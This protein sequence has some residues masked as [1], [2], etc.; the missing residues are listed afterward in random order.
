M[1]N[2]RLNNAQEL[3]K[4]L[5][6]LEKFYIPTTAPVTDPTTVAIVADDED[7]TVTTLGSFTTGADI[8]VVGTGRMELNRLGTV[9]GL[10]AIPVIRPFSLAQDAGAI[11]SIASRKD[12]GYIEDAGGS[13][14]SSSSKTGIGAANAGG[15]IAYLDGDTPEQQ[16]SWAVRESSLRNI[17]SAYGIDE[18]AIKGDGTDADP[19][20]GLISADN[21]GSQAN[22]CLR[23][24]GLLVSNKFLYFDMWNCT[25]EVSVSAQFIG[26]GQP[27]T[28]NMSVK[29]TDMLPY[30]LSTAI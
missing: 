28:W 1:S 7:I 22:F 26:K 19:Y 15:A 23:A 30:V 25:P 2:A 29:F 16:F 10:G 27:T 17:L 13:F 4:R 14:A 18:D 9:P 12:F 11:V 6:K 21:I 3:A 20:R 5:R 8:I 24:S